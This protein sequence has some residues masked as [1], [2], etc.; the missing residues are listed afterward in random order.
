MIS[1]QVDKASDCQCRCCNS[2]GFKSSVCR[3]S[4]FWGAADEA[5]LITVHEK[6]HQKIPLQNHVNLRDHV[7]SIFK[8]EMCQLS[9]FSSSVWKGGTIQSGLCPDHYTTNTEFTGTTPPQFTHFSQTMHSS[10]KL[11]P[12]TTNV[13]LGAAKSQ[14]TFITSP[15]LFSS[16]IK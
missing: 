3:H 8:Y 1:N 9:S 14:L 11:C 5:V 13:Y 6:Y 2:L 15:S 16:F 7:Q 10:E 4:G 12:L